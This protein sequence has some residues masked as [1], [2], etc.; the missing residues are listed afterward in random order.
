MDYR[1]RLFNILEI[2]NKDDRPSAIFDRFIATVIFVNLFVTLAQTFEQMA[3][4]M[5]FLNALELITI[6]IFLV[7]YVLRVW[8]ADYLYPEV[9][10][11]LKARIRFICS[12]YG[13]IDLF[14][15]IPYFLPFIFPAGAVAFRIFRVIRIFRLFS[16]SSG[17]SSA[18][19][20]TA[21]CLPS[22]S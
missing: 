8:T 3:Q 11:G 20:R 1:K 6:V 18:R 15:I 21:S 13:L 5:G 16:R 2:G 4:Y 14:A 17:V 19:S 12:A 9:V 7:E 10:S 22:S